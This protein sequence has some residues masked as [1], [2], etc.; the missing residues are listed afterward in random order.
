MKARKHINTNTNNGIPANRAPFK[1]LSI[2][3]VPADRGYDDGEN[4]DYL[5]T[6]NIHDAIM[7]KDIRTQKKDPNKAIWIELEKS[8]YYQHG[9]KKRPQIEKVF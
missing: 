8:I 9:K 3:L 1:P 4:H 7:L 2:K 5:K 6:K